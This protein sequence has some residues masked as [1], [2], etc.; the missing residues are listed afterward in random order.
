MIFFYVFRVVAILSFELKLG[1]NI[2]NIK[3][4]KPFHL[5]FRAI[6]SEKSIWQKNGNAER[7]F[8]INVT[9]LYL[10]N[11]HSYQMNFDNDGDNTDNRKKIFLWLLSWNLEI[12]METENNHEGPMK[13]TPTPVKSRISGQK[14]SPTWGWLVPMWYMVTEWTRILKGCILVHIW[15]GAMTFW[16]SHST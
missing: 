11:L 7:W 5:K 1:I 2:I 13:N 12:S 8:L 14:T 6:S 3:I 10:Y 4:Y 16:E 15:Y 9:V